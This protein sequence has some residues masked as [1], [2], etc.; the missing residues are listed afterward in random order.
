MTAPDVDAC[1][2]AGLLD[3]AQRADQD[4][5]DHKPTDA[6]A[7]DLTEEARHYGTVSQKGLQA[8]RAYRALLLG[9]ARGYRHEIN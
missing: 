7:D 8:H 3:G 5:S 1:Y 2:R 4:R 6:I 9:T